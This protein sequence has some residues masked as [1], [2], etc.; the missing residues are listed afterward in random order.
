M[1]AKTFTQNDKVTNNSM[2]LKY[3]IIGVKQVSRD[4]P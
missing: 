1:D 3:N 4:S 2:P